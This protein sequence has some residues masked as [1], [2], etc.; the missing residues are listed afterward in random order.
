M[1]DMRDD[2]AKC[3]LCADRFAATHTG[4]QPRQIVWFNPC[5]RVLIAGQAPGMRVHKSGVPFDGPSGDRL[6]AWLV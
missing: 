3:S 5:A 1:K 4:H 2:L 6:R